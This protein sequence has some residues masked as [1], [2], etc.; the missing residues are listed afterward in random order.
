MRQLGAPAR[1]VR[2]I[3]VLVLLLIVL[4]RNPAT[5]IDAYGTGPPYYGRATDIDE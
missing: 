5:L 3:F 1:I 2:S 4:W